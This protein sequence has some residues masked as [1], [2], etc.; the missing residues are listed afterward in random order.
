MYVAGGRGPL[1]RKMCKISIFNSIFSFLLQPPSRHL[2][3]HRNSPNPQILPGV[4]L[5]EPELG[6]DFLLISRWWGKT[7]GFEMKDGEFNR[8]NRWGSLRWVICNCIGRFY[9]DV[10]FLEQLLR[11]CLSGVEMDLHL[12]E[13]RI[14]RIYRAMKPTFQNHKKKHNWGTF[15]AVFKS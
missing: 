10:M 13:T 8:E 3:T 15:G 7:I 12:L 4:P 9:K 11:V 1:F 6:S 14:A 5:V 2:L